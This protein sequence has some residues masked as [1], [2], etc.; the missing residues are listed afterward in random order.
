MGFETAAIAETFAAHVTRVAARVNTFV[1]CVI[2][3]VREGLATV[4]ARIRFL[5]G[6]NA[7]VRDPRS[8]RAEELAT[9][10]TRMWFLPGVY[11][12]MLFQVRLAWKRL[13]TEFTRERFRAHVQLHV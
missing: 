9:V 1:A 13:V 4:S 5:S 6:V 11:E 8:R 2:S 12:Y 7:F 10:A 3:A